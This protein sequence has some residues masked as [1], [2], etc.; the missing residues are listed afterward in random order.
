MSGKVRMVFPMDSKEFYLKTYSKVSELKP[1]ADN[2][3]EMLTAAGVK[4]EIKENDR[5]DYD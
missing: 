5:V 4:F 3:S 1:L 2:I